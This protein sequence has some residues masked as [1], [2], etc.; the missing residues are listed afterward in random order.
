MSESGGLPLLEV[1][2]RAE[3]DYLALLVDLIH[4]EVAKSVLER[5]LQLYQI[6]P[7]ALRQRVSVE[8]LNANVTFTEVKLFCDR[9]FLLKSLWLRIGLLVRPSFLVWYFDHLFCVF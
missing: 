8:E 1:S 2:L 5:A 6:H 3:P 4:N 7:L 9:F